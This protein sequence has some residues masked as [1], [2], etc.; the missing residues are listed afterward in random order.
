MHNIWTKLFNCDKINITALVMYCHPVVSILMHILNI[1][2]IFAISHF[3]EN[4]DLS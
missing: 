4:D 1:L 3:Y 2:R